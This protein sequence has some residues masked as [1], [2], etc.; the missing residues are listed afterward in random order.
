V[1]SL[2]GCQLPKRCRKYWRYC[3]GVKETYK[4]HHC[5]C[6]DALCN[7]PISFRGGGFVIDNF[8]KK[9]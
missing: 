1:V 4:G 7:M 5:N 8:V 6:N 9:I 3:L 2:E